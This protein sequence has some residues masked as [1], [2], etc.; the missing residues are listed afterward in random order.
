M[1]GKG[2][3]VSKKSRL[4]NP[5]KRGGTQ[6]MGPEIFEWKF[7]LIGCRSIIFL[8]SDEKFWMKRVDCMQ[9]VGYTPSHPPCTCMVFSFEYVQWMLNNKIYLQ[10]PS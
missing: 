3:R 4:I 2:K 10:L 8:K 6:G 1:T 5:Q 7:F 9:G